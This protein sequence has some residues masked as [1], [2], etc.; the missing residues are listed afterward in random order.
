MSPRSGA[1]ETAAD[2]KDHSSLLSEARLSRT[3]FVSGWSGPSGAVHL[4]DEAAPRREIPGLD[5]SRVPRLLQ[6]PGDPLGPGAI[7]LGVADEEVG[8][9]LHSGESPGTVILD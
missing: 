2:G 4:H 7:G 5:A 1:E 8:A 6:G 3:I 9:R